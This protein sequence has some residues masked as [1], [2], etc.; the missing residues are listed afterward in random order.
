MS[1][2]RQ[3]AEPGDD[4]KPKRSRGGIKAKVDVEPQPPASVGA[5][6][7]NAKACEVWKEHRKRKTVWFT[8]PGP[9]GEYF[10]PLSV[11]G[12]GTKG[13]TRDGKT[14][15]NFSPQSTQ[16]VKL[17]RHLY[18]KAA[19]VTRLCPH[20]PAPWRSPLCSASTTRKPP[21]QRTYAR[22]GKHPDTARYVNPWSLLSQLYLGAAWDVGW[23]WE[24]QSPQVQ[25]HRFFPPQALVEDCADM[26]FIRNLDYTG[27]A[28]KSK[29]G[30]SSPE[31][32]LI[33]EEKF[34]CDYKTLLEGPPGA[35]LL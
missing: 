14:Q 10:D 20:W 30:L 18:N 26:D 16:A 7:T 19:D 27:S 31:A 32:L 6:A 2:K 33:L 11:W 5:G 1:N 22:T 4:D 24:T 12:N 21:M 34:G 3:T 13:I 35:G 15:T 9:N 29:V 17:L 23:R 25:N 28:A 8:P